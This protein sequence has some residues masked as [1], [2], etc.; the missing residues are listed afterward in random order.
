MVCLH[1]LLHLSPAV[2]LLLARFVRSFGTFT[3]SMVSG[4]EH[5]AAWAANVLNRRLINDCSVDFVFILTDILEGI[6][7]CLHIL[8]GLTKIGCVACQGIW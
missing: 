6:L 1:H 2:L 7:G 4:A 5:L 8:D 3:D